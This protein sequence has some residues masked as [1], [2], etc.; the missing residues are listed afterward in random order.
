[1]KSGEKMTANVNRFPLRAM[2][3]GFRRF[4]VDEYEKLVHIGMITEDDDL[5]LL[6]GYL[7][8]KMGHNP[9]HDGTIQLVY[10][11]LALVLTPGW[12]IRV[13]SVV[14]LSTSE[15]E[16]DLALVRGTIRSFLKVHPRSPEIG[17]VVEVADS[18]LNSDRLDK[19]MI[20]AS[21]QLP[22]YWI[23]NV[24]NEQIEVYTDPTPT[25]YATRTDFKPGD[26]VPLVLD[27]VEVAKLAVADLL[28]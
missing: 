24:A 2:T 7:V 21:N 17:L 8:H 12:C 1:M 6:D 10:A 11:A 5:E 20:Y 9:P 18:T 26:V 19:T 14:R 16:P 22:C 25:G 13:Q 23:V 4:T 3:A 27:G 28:P 15:P